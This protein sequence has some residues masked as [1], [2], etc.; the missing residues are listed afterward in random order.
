M[1]FILL[2][3]T[4]LMQVTMAQVERGVAAEDDA[5]ST[6]SGGIIA[7]I[8]IGVALLAATFIFFCLRCMKSE[9]ERMEELH[10]DETEAR[11]TQHQYG[12]DDYANLQDDKKTNVMA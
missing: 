7:L 9:N 12:H 1:L 5:D 2:T 11:E 10:H 4:S 6:V 8:L 3:T